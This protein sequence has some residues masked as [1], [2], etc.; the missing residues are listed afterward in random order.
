MRLMT[1]PPSPLIAPIFNGT[2]TL[3]SDEAEGQRIAV[4][5]THDAFA[6]ADQFSETTA[7]QS[8][9]AAFFSVDCG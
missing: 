4:R 6:M 3:L 8:W 1:E 5:E 9:I 7:V 2:Q